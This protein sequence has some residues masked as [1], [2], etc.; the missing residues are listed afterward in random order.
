MTAM[1]RNKYHLFVLPLGL[2]AEFP[3]FSAEYRDSSNDVNELKK[4]VKTDGYLKALIYEE[5]DDGKLKPFRLFWELWDDC[6][7]HPLERLS[8]FSPPDEGPVCPDCGELEIS[9][10]SPKECY[11]PKSIESKWW[12]I[13]ERNV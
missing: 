12:L 4:T 3:F 5:Q 2:R 13:L 7:G 9:H 11:S 10:P 1:I 8:T 6:H